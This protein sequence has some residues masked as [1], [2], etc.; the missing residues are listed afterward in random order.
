MPVTKVRSTWEDIINNNPK[1]VRLRSH[2]SN[3][4]MYSM[5]TLISSPVSIYCIV[6]T[7]K[8]L[9]MH[10]SAHAVSGD[11]V[12]DDLKKYYYAKHSQK[13]QMDYDLVHLVHELMEKSL[14]EMQSYAHV[15]LDNLVY[16]TLDRYNGNI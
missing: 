2:N 1:V 15:S 7:I 10:L 14:E 4:D 9:M 3:Q 11:N 8:N 16:D 5:H 13:E 12:N 6:W